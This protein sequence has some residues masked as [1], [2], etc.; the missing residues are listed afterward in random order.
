MRNG[1]YFLKARHD[2]FP[3]PPYFPKLISWEHL[4]A[5]EFDKWGVYLGGYVPN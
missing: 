5:R 1:K 3:F 4:V 2:I